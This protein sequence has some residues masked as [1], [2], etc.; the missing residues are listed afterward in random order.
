MLC[1][2]MADQ[3]EEAQY[4]MRTIE[5]GGMGIEVGPAIYDGYVLAC[6]RSQQWDDIMELFH[7]MKS[8]NLY[9]PS[10]PTSHGILLARRRQ[11]ATKDE[12]EALVDDLINFGAQF[13]RD[14][15]LLSASILLSHLC[16]DGKSVSS[17]R[18]KLRSNLPKPEGRRKEYIVQL[19]RS[20]RIAE[21]E[22]QR[23][24]Q[25]T[26]SSEPGSEL[27]GKVINDIMQVAKCDQNTE[28]EST[29]TKS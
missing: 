7:R 15:A 4:L 2:A 25:S 10:A 3:I 18:T 16:G 9:S 17:V 8:Q 6:V 11:G 26:S 21:M 28:R 20:L 19:I 1:Y 13:N 5:S 24:V 14:F 27:W 12:I 29:T 23:N 22:E